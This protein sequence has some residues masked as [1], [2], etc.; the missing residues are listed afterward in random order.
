[1][2]SVPGQPDLDLR[3]LVQLLKDAAKT[4]IKDATKSSFFMCVIFLVKR[5]LMQIVIP[6]RYNT[7]T[8][9]RNSSNITPQLK[10]YQ[11][12]KLILRL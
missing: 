3:L 12:T 5:V 10:S 8:K 11:K 9:R 2:P 7:S 6:Q 4:I 1:M